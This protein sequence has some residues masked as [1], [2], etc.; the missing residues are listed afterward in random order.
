[1]VF[2]DNHVGFLP[3]NIDELTMAYLISNND[4]Q[5]VDISKVR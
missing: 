4:G 2:L 5:T 1:V 3:D